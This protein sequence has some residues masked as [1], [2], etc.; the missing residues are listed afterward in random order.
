MA[1][2][3]FENRRGGRS[4]TRGHVEGAVADLSAAQDGVL[5]TQDLLALGLSRA[6]IQNRSA[7]GSLHR[8]YPGVY[9][10]GDPLLSLRGRWLAAVRACGPGAVL[11]HRDAAML[12]GLMRSSRPRIDVTAAG[13][14]GRKLRG[15]DR[16]TAILLPRDRCVNAGIPC[17][18]PSRT[19]LDFAA[20]AD[21]SP[22]REG[23]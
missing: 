17:T 23:I 10:V 16:H 7:R 19:M 8:L 9:A 20:V 18:S 13:Q 11:S 6:A 5:T 12:L 15:I 2:Q 4:G 3:L 21:T 22:P 1:D 14:R